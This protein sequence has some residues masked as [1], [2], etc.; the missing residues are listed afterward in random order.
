MRFTQKDGSQTIDT[1]DALALQEYEDIQMLNG[2]TR[3][4]IHDT[5]GPK[6]ATKKRR[7]L[8]GKRTWKDK[9]RQ[10]AR[11]EGQMAVK[12]FNGKKKAMKA[13]D[14]I[15]KEKTRARKRHSLVD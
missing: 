13:L 4:A 1:E 11:L 3:R 8:P 9:R 2:R 5:Y 10:Y 7:K 6:Q 15:Y 12:E 14:N